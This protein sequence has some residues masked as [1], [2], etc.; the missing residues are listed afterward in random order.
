VCVDLLL[1][2]ML[3]ANFDVKKVV[4][5]DTRYI[6]LMQSDIYSISSLLV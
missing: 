4:V 3:N 5:G 1:G 6:E 2:Y